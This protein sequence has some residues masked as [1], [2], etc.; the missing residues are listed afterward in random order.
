M[1]KALPNHIAKLI[2]SKDCALVVIDKQR[3]YMDAGTLGLR[4][5]HLTADFTVRFNV[6][7]Q[8]ILLCRSVNIPIIWTQMV[9]DPALSPKN[10]AYIMQNDHNDSIATPGGDSFDIYG[11]VHPLKTE[12]IITKYHYDCFSGTDMANYLEKI[13]TQTLI[14]CGGFASRCVLGSGFVASGLEYNCIFIKDA[15]INPKEYEGELSLALD[16]MSGILGYC[17]NY[18]EFKSAATK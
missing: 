18:N 9:E 10:I 1:S 12:K 13:S 6:L 8:L 17:L 2:N 7:E 15:L 5:K 3:A 11:K 14:F 16:T 4:N